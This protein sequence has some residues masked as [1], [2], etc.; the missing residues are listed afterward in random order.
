[1]NYTVSYRPLT[2]CPAKAG[3]FTTPENNFTLIGLNNYTD[4][5]ITVFASTVKGNGNVSAA[6][7]IRTGQD[8]KC[9]LLGYF[10]YMVSSLAEF[11]L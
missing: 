3:N 10:C 2:D 6:K 7:I 4:Y 9:T 1:M 11:E 5:S 8:G